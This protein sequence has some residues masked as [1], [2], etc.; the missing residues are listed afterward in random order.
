VTESQPRLFADPDPKPW[1]TRARTTDPFT[2]FEAAASIPDRQVRAVHRRILEA[3]AVS[4]GRTDEQLGEVAEVLGWYTSPSGM[5]TRRSEL[6]E[7]GLVRD[8]GRRM[9]T[10]SG[11]RAII[12]EVVAE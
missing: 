10:R 7:A 6:V 11:R 8:S 9:R 4:G 3:L 2:S 12:W 1:Q 5:R